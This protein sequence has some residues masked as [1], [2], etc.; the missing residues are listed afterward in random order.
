M[1]FANLLATL[2]S[3][4]TAQS[5]DP[6]LAQHTALFEK[7]IYHVTA[8]VYSAVGYSLGN[9][10]L[11]EG[12]TGVIV[13]DTLSSVEAA[14]Q[15]REEFR[16]ITPKPVVAVIYTHFHPDHVHGVKAF[17]DS[18]SVEVYA[19]ESLLDNYVTQGALIG[20]ILG[21]RSS[22]SFGAGMTAEE[23]Q[24]MNFGLGPI[25]AP[26]T[27]TFIQPTKTF[28]DRMDV[29]IAGVQLRLLHAPSETPDHVTVFLPESRLLCSADMIQGPAFPNIHTLRGAS[30]RDP[31]AWV[32]SIDAM[33]ALHADFLAPSHG[34]P[35][36]GRDKVEEV[37]RNYRDGIQFVHDQTIRYMN[38]GL[39]PDEL[40]AKVKLPPH[41][42]NY[43][44]Y[45][46]PFYGTVSHS[47][48]EIYVGYL[49]W[50]EGDPTALDPTPPAESARRQVGLM[51]GRDRVLQEAKGALDAGDAQWSAELASYLIRMNR[52][53]RD[54]RQMKAAAL[55]KLGLAQK[56]TNWRNWYLASAHELDGSLDTAAVLARA[57]T[58][59]GAPETIA[60]LP[61]RV[62]VQ[63][64]T[65]R[66]EAEKTLDVH[67]TMSFWFPD[68]KEEYA[69]EVRRGVAQFSDRPGLA[70][71]AIELEKATLDQI[72]LGRSSIVRALNSGQMKVTKGDRADVLKF[73]GYFEPAFADPIALTV[74]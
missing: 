48:R 66:L 24:G 33:R 38:K 59:F 47:V 28:R 69:L 31:R 8:N 37:M 4:A 22:Y 36:S 26:G 68:T 20:P 54:A 42:E 2:A 58:N 17:A 70:D 12:D 46:R 14:R 55:R 29:T 64:L 19:H 45:L 43:A 50:F 23:R 7:K 56:N 18:P 74:R 11:I 5:I 39:T 73:F 60:A 21:V 25:Y 67:T 13:V 10:I 44:P 51:G 53:D 30:F 40:V 6:E 57:R 34:Q 61:A 35:V 63:G 1:T 9:S 16:K 49:G 3:L 52:D 65:T 72:L 32:G 41:L 71:V 62:W 27:S 15:V